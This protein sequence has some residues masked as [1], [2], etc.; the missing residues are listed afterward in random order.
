MCILHDLPETRIGDLN[1]VHKKY[2]QADEEKAIM[3]AV[4]DLPF[5]ADWV[6]LL[7]EFNHGDSI[8]AQLARDADQISLILELKHLKDIGHTPATDWLPNVINRLQTKIGKQV[9]RAVLA[10]KHDGWWRRVCS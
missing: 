3:D 6:G 10:T 8:E 2:V 5:G 9:A 4:Q 1:T 7:A